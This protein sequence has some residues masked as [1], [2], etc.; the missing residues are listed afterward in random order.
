VVKENRMGFPRVRAPQQDYIRFFDFTIRAGPAARS[1]Y[2]RQ[3]GD[4]WRVSSPVATIDVVAA[5]HRPDKFLGCVIQLVRRF[6]AAEHP[7]R[8]RRLRSDLTP[9]ACGDEIQRFVP[10][11]RAVLSILANERGCQTL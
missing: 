9:N 10:G 1:E 8:A 5:D 7:E 4:A 6:R 2:R 3:T 11:C